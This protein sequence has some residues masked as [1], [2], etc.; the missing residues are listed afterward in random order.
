MASI[1]LMCSRAEVIDSSIQRVV[2][3][4]L[5]VDM[6]QYWRAGLQDRKVLTRS[7]GKLSINGRQHV[8]GQ[9][10]RLERHERAKRRALGFDS[11]CLCQY[12]LILLRT[13]SLLPRYSFVKRK[14][15][16]KARRNI[17]AVPA[18][19]AS[20]RLK[21]QRRVYTNPDPITDSRATRACSSNESIRACFLH[22]DCSR[23][24]L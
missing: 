23:L 20:S 5:M 11:F 18:T 22:G 14:L 17:C 16:L 12:S 7:W 4:I 13:Q 1:P 6:V 3:S 19:A 24:L 9:C 2:R 15:L 8:D 21:S 10:E